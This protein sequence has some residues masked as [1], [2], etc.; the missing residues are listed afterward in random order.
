MNFGCIDGCR[1]LNRSR[2]LKFEKNLD[3]DWKI[4]EQKSESENVTPTTSEAQLA[5]LVTSCCADEFQACVKKVPVDVWCQYILVLQISSVLFGHNQS[6]VQ[7]CTVRRT[8]YHVIIPIH[9]AFSLHQSPSVCENQPPWFVEVLFRF[10]FLFDR[11][12]KHVLLL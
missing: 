4:L 3:P 2:I 8:P 1:S 12:R 5:R 10:V 11:W 6:N 7:Q 9:R